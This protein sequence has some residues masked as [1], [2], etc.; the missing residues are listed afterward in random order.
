LEIPANPGLTIITYGAEPGSPSA[1]ALGQLAGSA[2]PGSVP[3][4]PE[5]PES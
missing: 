3:A 5:A 4:P 1:R 2:P